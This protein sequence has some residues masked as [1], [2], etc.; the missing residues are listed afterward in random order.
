[1]HGRILVDGKDMTHVPASKRGM[2]IV[3]QAYSLFPNM[4]TIENVGYGLR[5]RGVGKDERRTA[6]RR[7][8]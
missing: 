3:F 8:A 1:M 2:G 5:L 4:T 7:D 6:G